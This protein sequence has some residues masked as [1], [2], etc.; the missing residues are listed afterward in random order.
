VRLDLAGRDPV[1]SH[2][3]A[4]ERALHGTRRTLERLAES[5]GAS[6]R[7]LGATVRRLRRAAREWRLASS[8]ELDRAIDRAAALP[9][10]LDALEALLAHVAAECDRPAP[11]LEILDGVD[12]GDG[13]SPVRVSASD[14]ETLWRNLFRNALGSG[15]LAV[16]AAEHRDPATGEAR[17]RF[18]LFDEL[19]ETVGPDAVRE[20]PADRGLGIVS[21]ILTRNDGS[22]HVVPAEAP[23]FTKGLGFELPA[24]ETPA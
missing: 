12:R 8:A 13:L 5:G 20:R 7:A 18:V 14:W 23:G 3:L 11:P 6:D 16:S 4:G 17:L 22:F 15:R 21:E 1:L 10:R 24:V 9:V 19:P 2:V